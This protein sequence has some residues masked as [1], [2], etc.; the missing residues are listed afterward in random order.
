MPVLPASV[1]LALWATSAYGGGVGLDEAIRLATPDADSVDG[2]EAR[3]E[4]WRDLGERVVLVALVRPGDLTGLPSGPADFLAAALEAGECVFVPG[5]GGAL[6][7]QVGEYGPAGD[8]GFLVR[9]VPYDCDPTPAHVLDGLSLRETEREVR[10]QIR[11][12]TTELEAGGSVP[13]GSRGLAQLAHERVYQGRW[14]LPTGVTPRAAG[15][16]ALSAAMGEL[17]RLGLDSP[18]DGPTASAVETRRLTLRRLAAAGDR[19]LTTATNVAALG[20]AGYRRG[21]DD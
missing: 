20:L 5:L 13:W 8:E 17:A 9:W 2:A 21:R 14:G 12:A 4:V 11:E 3:L 7:P 15:L 18:D 1:R 10:Q 19:A 6:V 16:L